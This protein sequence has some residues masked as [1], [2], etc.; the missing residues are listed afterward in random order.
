M[1]GAWRQGFDARLL[2]AL[3]WG[4]ANV[5]H[6]KVRQQEAICGPQ[7]A[8]LNLN[9]SVNSNEAIKAQVGTSQPTPPRTDQEAVAADEPDFPG[10][11]LH[12]A[13]GLC[14]RICNGH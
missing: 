9:H 8:A 4:G 13:A 11:A 2:I 1:G 14:F 10:A 5:F 7:Y 6:S 3:A 12:G